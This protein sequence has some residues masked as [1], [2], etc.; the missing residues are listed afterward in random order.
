[1]NKTTECRE[2]KRAVVVLLPFSALPPYGEFAA[3]DFVCSGGVSSTSGIHGA[4]LSVSY[5]NS[6]TGNDHSVGQDVG[7][8]SQEGSQNEAGWGKD[9]GGLGVV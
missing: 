3:G 4:G 8:G 9:L 7:S 1:M 2:A 5:R 6:A